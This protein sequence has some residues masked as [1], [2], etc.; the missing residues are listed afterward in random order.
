VRKAPGSD[1]TKAVCLHLLP[2]PLPDNLDPALWHE[3]A[4]AADFQQTRDLGT[5][6][7]RLRESPIGHLRGTA[8]ARTPQPAG[9]CTLAG[10]T[11]P[12]VCLVVATGEMPL[13]V[14]NFNGVRRVTREAVLLALAI[15]S[16]IRAERMTPKSNVCGG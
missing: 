4:A 1:R 5:T 2:Q 6:V 13:Q 15:P 16:L 12:L 8:K 10:L 11:D 7:G 9:W 3:L 14:W